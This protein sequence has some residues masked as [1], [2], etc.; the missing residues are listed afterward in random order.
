MFMVKEILIS[1]RQMKR[2]RR[3][4]NFFITFILFSAIGGS[5]VGIFYYHK[6]RMSDLRVSGA[7]TLK[8]KEVIDVA[9]NFL[10]KKILYIL[11]GDNFV[12]LRGDELVSDLLKI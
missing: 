12:L 9:R 4:L 3:I 6:W 10:D 11:P 8:N 1:S 5:V 7:E 2:R